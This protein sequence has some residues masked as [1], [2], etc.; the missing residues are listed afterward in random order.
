MAGGWA[1]EGEAA[2]L[3]TATANPPAVVTLPGPR[4]RTTATPAEGRGGV[5]QLERVSITTEQLTVLVTPEAVAP[6]PVPRRRVGAGLAVGVTVLVAAL[7]AVATAFVVSVTYS[8]FI[9]FRF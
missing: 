4:P 9:Y 1:G 3:D 7:L 5:A 6:E 8:P 2:P